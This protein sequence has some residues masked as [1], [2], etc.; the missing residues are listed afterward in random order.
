VTQYCTWCQYDL[1][2]PEEILD[3]L[4]EDCKQKWE[5]RRPLAQ[6]I[7]EFLR[8]RHAY[9]PQLAVDIALLIEQKLDGHG[10]YNGGWAGGIE[11]HITPLGAE[12][13]EAPQEE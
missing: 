13:S 1:Y 8:A 12:Q 7:E 3:G 6:F 5:R 9:H 2:E 4:H 11:D 10:K